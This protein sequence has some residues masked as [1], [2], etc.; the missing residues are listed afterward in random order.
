MTPFKEAKQPERQRGRKSVIIWPSII[1]LMGHTTTKKMRN[2]AVWENV[3]PC[4]WQT[5]DKIWRSLSPTLGLRWQSKINFAYAFKR[6]FN[7]VASLGGKS[8]QL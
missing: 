3:Q 8:S 2:A 7:K 6:I 1:T 4:P 5:Y